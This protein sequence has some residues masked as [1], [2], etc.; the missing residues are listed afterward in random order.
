MGTFVPK[1]ILFNYISEV[2]VYLS[3][4]VRYVFA[5]VILGRDAE[6]TRDVVSRKRLN[7]RN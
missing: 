6:T 5:V 1:Y 4:T 2:P 3:D 7:A